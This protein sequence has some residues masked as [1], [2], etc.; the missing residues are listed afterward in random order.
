MGGDIRHSP[1]YGKAATQRHAGLQPPND[2]TQHPSSMPHALKRTILPSLGQHTCTPP[3]ALDTALPWVL[4]QPLR[5]PNIASPTRNHLQGARR[6][7]LAAPRPRARLPS[8]PTPSRR[9]RTPAGACSS[10]LDLRCPYSCISRGLPPS[11]ARALAPRQRPARIR[12]LPSCVRSG[13]ST[14]CAHNTPPRARLRC[15]GVLRVPVTCHQAS[16]GPARLRGLSIRGLLGEEVAT[17]SRSS[18]SIG[19]VSVSVVGRRTP[20]F[21]GC[22]SPRVRGRT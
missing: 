19:S 5:S 3:P 13:G 4:P 11:R 9:P 2:P 8:P 10:H 22:D 1:Q 18:L 15:R 21:P 12:A 14:V 20:S 16:L 17:S 7:A 6:T